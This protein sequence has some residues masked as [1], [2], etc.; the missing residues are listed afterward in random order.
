[1][2][3]GE[4]FSSAFPQTV[5]SHDPEAW[6]HDLC[7]FT[8]SASIPLVLPSGAAGSNKTIPGFVDCFLLF[9]RNNFF[10]LLK[11]LDGPV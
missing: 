10:Q 1:M 9:R 6:S 5:L 4:N 11:V 3:L 7:A 2:L 8:A